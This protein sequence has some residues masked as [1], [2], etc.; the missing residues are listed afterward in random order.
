MRFA[1][2]PFDTAKRGGQ[3]FVEFAMNVAEKFGGA[4]LRGGHFVHGGL[5]PVLCLDVGEVNL[6]ERATFAVGGK[7]MGERGVDVARQRAM[8]LDEVRVVAVHRTHQRGDAAARDGLQCSAQTF[9]AA[10][11]FKS[12]RGEVSVAVF[13]QE[14]LKIGRMIEQSSQDSG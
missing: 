1:I 3:A 4:D 14:R 11:Q 9:R 2:V 7:F 5:H 6:L 13:R 10:E 8:A 12:E